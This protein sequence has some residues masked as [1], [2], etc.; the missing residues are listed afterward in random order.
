MK[1]IFEIP[2]IFSDKFPSNFIN[3]VNGWSFTEE[4]LKR[5]HGKLLT[6][7]IDFGKTCGLNCSQCFRRNNKVDNTSKKEMSYDET[8]SLIL[9]TKKLGLR[10]VK[11][12]GKGEPFENPRF[13][14]FLRFLRSIDIAPLVFTKGTVFGNDKLAKNT[15]IIMEL[16]MELTLLKN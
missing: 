8:V 14:E 6:L 15:T 13:L 1:N 4:E 12:L 10:S 16:I 5:N 7:D 11:F 2:K 9:A 3:D